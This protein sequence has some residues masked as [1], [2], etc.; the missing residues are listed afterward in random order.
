MKRRTVINLGASGALLATLPAWAADDKAP[1]AKPGEWS[2]ADAPIPVTAADPTWGDRKAPITLVV[3]GN[4]QCPFCEKLTHTIDELEKKY[5]KGK[6]RVVW[7]HL[8]LAMHTRAK[9]AAIAAATVFKLKGADA[10]WK[11]SAL[12]YKNQRDFTEQSLPG[13]AKQV[14]VSEKAFAEELA[15]GTGAAKVQAD[16]DLADA[17][18]VVATPSSF[19]N[20]I[21]ISG[22]QKIE[23]FVEVFD[24][25]LAAAEAAIKAGTKADR[26]YVERTKLN[27][28]PKP[29]TPRPPP[30]PVQAP[31]PVPVPPPAKP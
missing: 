23:K 30:P 9:P 22:A 1:K 10:F 28:V 5:G 4:Y 27:F 14:G 29:A 12:V 16:L 2:D 25:E 31:A 17:L 7:K 3:F 6:L 21:A 26:V 11:F 13:L 8:P 18:R 20:G 15:K 24:P 19:L